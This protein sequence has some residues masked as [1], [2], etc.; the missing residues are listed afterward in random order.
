MTDKHGR[1]PV[2]CQDCETVPKLH[3]TPYKQTGY[4]VA[5]ECGRRSIDVTDAVNGNALTQPLSGLWSN[6]DYDHE[7]DRMD[8]E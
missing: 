3:E 7:A 8:T 6:I 4:V 2:T 5:C 1:Q